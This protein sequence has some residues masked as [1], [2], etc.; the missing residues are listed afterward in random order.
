MAKLTLK[1]EYKKKQ[2]L[3]FEFDWQIWTC[4]ALKKEWLNLHI[5]S[6]MKSTLE[7]FISIIIFLQYGEAY[8]NGLVNL[9]EKK[10]Y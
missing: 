5:K 7:Y 6:V 4:H 8:K 1:R 9:L 3:F 10:F 2:K